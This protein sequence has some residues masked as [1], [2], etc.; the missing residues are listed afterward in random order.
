[1]PAIEVQDLKKYYG[2]THAVDGISFSVEQGEI[3]GMLGPNGAG[4]STTTEIVEG[5][6][7]PDSGSV[8]VLG[9]D[10]TRV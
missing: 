9:W 2:A 7:K 4:K 1:M 3:F 8:R 6:R 10:V 5:L